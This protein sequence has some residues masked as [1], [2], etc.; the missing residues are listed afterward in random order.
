MKRSNKI[1]ISTPNHDE[2]STS[3]QSAVAGTSK[4]KRCSSSP[5]SSISSD[6]GLAVTKK[7]KDQHESSVANSSLDIS[8]N[9]KSV[10]PV[11]RNKK[12]EVLKTSKD[13]TKKN[14]CYYC[15]IDQQKNKNP[16]KK[17]IIPNF[18]KKRR[19]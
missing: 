6:D 9:L 14:T 8:I 13:G 17:C 1:K 10:G 7:Q 11:L 16:D 18:Q 15:Y 12:N 5:D 4:R 19:Q 3:D 2:I